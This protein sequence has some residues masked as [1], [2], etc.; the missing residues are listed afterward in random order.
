[1]PAIRKR[2]LLRRLV[3]WS[4][5]TMLTAVGGIVLQCGLLWVDHRRATALPSPSGAFAVGRTLLA[6]NV[7]PP[8]SAIRGAERPSSLRCCS[9]Q[10]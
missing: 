3:Q 1:M 6:W 9:V 8:H 2:T 5:V 4:A 7:S 10:P